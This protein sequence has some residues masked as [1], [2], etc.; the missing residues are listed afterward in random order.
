MQRQGETA[1]LSNSHFVNVSASSAKQIAQNILMLT[2]PAGCKRTTYT[3]SCQQIHKSPP[4]VTLPIHT[5]HHNIPTSTAQLLLIVLRGDR[6]PFHA[7]PAIA[8][9]IAFFRSTRMAPCTIAP[10]PGRPPHA[11]GCSTHLRLESCEQLQHVRRRLPLR[12][13]TQNLLHNSVVRF[14]R[15]C[16]KLKI[17]CTAVHRR[18]CVRARSAARYCCAW[19]EEGWCCNSA[20]LKSARSS[21]GGAIPAAMTARPCSPSL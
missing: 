6:L 7:F 9:D 5:P 19:C 11:S 17:C 8:I 21:G 14:A 15:T 3:V 20:T 12:H 10:A 4:Q 16:L 13:A 1:L 2:E 18:A